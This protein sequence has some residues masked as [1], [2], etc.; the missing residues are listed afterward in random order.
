MAGHGGDGRSAVLATVTIV[1]RDYA[2]VA[3]RGAADSP[4][5][6]GRAVTRLAALAR[7]PP[8][9]LVLDLSDQ[10]S[11]HLR[12][13]MIKVALVGGGDEVSPSR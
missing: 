13:G 5:G 9:P 11:P 3:M 2:G 4:A 1:N 12:E 10:V 8:R 6:S 7:F